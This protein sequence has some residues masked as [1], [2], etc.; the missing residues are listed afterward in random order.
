[1]NIHTLLLDADGVL[2]RPTVGWRMAFQS[3]LGIDDEP[4]LDRFIDD[5]LEAESAFLASPKGFKERI[6]TVLCKWSRP[7]SAPDVIDAMNSIEIYEDVMEAVQN[8][9]SA[10]IRCHIASNQQALRAWHMSEVLNYKSLFDR[11]FYSCFLGV[12]KPRTDFFEKVLDALNCDGN[13]VLFIDDREENIAAAKKA[14]LNATI[15]LGADGAAALLR[16]LAG[17]GLS[18]KSEKGSRLDS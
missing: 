7:E 9:R 15:C 12:A 17:Y 10:G 6:E 1:M 4:P 3:I 14:G 18:V 8:Y 13:E 2:Q 5:I 16:S 11:E